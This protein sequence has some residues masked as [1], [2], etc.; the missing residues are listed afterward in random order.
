MSDEF[1]KKLAVIAARAEAAKQKGPAATVELKT[2]LDQ[3]I[4]KVKAGT[5]DWRK[6]IKRLI[7]AAVKEANSIAANGIYLAPKDDDSKYMY[8]ADGVTLFLPYVTISATHGKP[9]GRSPASALAEAPRASN[10]VLPNILISLDG[11]GRIR[12]KFTTLTTYT[13]TADGPFLPEQF[14]EVQIEAAIYKFIKA[15]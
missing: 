9:A 1:K 4:A 15:L 7:G 3:H 14:G 6:R 11:D 13:L 5:A 8:A 2:A 12:I 10:V